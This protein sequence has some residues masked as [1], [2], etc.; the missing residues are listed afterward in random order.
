M[1][2]LKRP[3]RRNL[4]D[5]LQRQM[6]T[7]WGAWA[8]P[9]YLPRENDRA[10]IAAGRPHRQRRVP[11][12]PG[13]GGSLRHSHFRHLQPVRSDFRL[14]L[15]EAEAHETGGCGYDDLRGRSHYHQL[16]EAG[17]QPQFYPG[18]HLRADR[19]GELGPGGN[20]LQLRR[21]HDRYGCGGEPAGADLRR[22]GPGDH[23]S[24]GGWPGAAGRHHG[25]GASP[26][27]AGCGRAERG[28][29]LCLLV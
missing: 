18:N 3:V 9:Q 2:R 11:G 6:R 14:D 27:V 4:A 17:G 7:A 23:R 22:G 13:D 15:P 10:G 16:G 26:S 29:V 21:S 8:E 12:G 25:C 5:H 1:F 19:G 20:A 28:G 24:P